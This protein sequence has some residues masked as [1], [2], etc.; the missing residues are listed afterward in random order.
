MA[1][2]SAKGD[3]KLAQMV[4]ERQDLSQ[5]WRLRDKQ[6]LAATSTPLAQRNSAAEG[7]QRS[8]LAEI[9]ARVAEIDAVLARDFPD[10][11][12]LS[13]PEPMR[14]A[15]VQAQLGAN[16]AL[17]LFLDTGAMGLSADKS[18]IPEE[19]FV[20]VVAKTEIRW[21]RS[22]AGAGTLSRTIAALRCGLDATAWAVGNKLCRP[23]QAGARQCPS[24]TAAVRYDGLIRALQVAVRQGGGSDPRQ[25]SASC[26][27]G[28]LTQLPFPGAGDRTTAIGGSALGQ[29]A[30][31]HKRTDRVAG[32]VFTWC[33]A[34]GG[35]AER[36]HQA[37][38]RVR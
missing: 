11:A 18:V 6:L 29:M 25:A 19:T 14:I 37:D 13:N 16:Q 1:A 23:P 20:W 35:P 33:A 7:R 2:R 12:A 4:R 10:Y 24:Q 21:L 36:R 26:P 8:R 32:R 17:V 27:L 28:A 31:S 15:D 22:E 30:G 5:E 3:T 38:D 34:P 9:G